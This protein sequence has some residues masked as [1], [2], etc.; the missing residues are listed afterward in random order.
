MGTFSYFL[1]LSKRKGYNHGERISPNAVTCGTDTL[2][3]VSERCIR[4]SCYTNSVSNAV[5][6]IQVPLSFESIGLAACFDVLILITGVHAS[7]QAEA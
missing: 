6:V 3:R 5:M 7:M 4:T 1:R 2:S